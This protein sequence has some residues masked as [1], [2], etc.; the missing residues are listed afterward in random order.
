MLGVEVPAGALFYA[1]TR[2]REDIPFDDALRS[3][4]ERSAERLHELL[5]SGKTPPGIREKKC[6]RCSLLEVCL[7]E[8]SRRS[9]RSYLAHFLQQDTPEP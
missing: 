6:D 1:R 8:A 9:A 7:P 3:L 4:T 5:R 2:R